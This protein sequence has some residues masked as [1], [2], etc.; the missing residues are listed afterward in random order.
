MAVKVI[1]II[2]IKIVNIPF[3][4]YNYTLCLF[5]KKETNLFNLQFTTTLPTPQYPFWVTPGR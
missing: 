5:S 1:K 2:L 4:K 3:T